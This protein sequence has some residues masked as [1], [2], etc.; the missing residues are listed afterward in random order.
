MNA[1]ARVEKLAEK[2]LSHMGFE[3]VRVRLSGS[4]RPVLEVMIDRLD[5]EHVT[6]DDCVEVSRSLSHILDAHDPVDQAYVLE[7]TSPGVERPLTKPSHYSKVLG[8]SIKVEMTADIEGRRKWV[9]VLHAATET[10]FELVVTNDNETRTLALPIAGVLKAKV[11][12]LQEQPV[13]AKNKKA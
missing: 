11:V 9:G 7:V 4:H 8:Q 2:T 6:M 1:A 12:L 5:G 13:K 10:N 3:L